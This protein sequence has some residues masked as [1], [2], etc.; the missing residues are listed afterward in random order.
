MPFTPI[1]EVSNGVRPEPVD[2]A[3]PR[4]RFTPVEGIGDAAPRAR[5][6]PIEE[7]ERTPPAL[8]QPSPQPTSIART[9][10]LENP[11][12]AIGEAGLNLG[13]QMVAQP[14]A[15][16]AGLA[17]LGGRALGLTDREPGDVVHSVGSALTYMP[18]GKMGQ[19]A[20]EIVAY[21]FQKLAEAGQWVGGKTLEATGSPLA[22]TVA[23]TAIN[24][25][26][27]ALT[28]SAIKRVA[29]KGAPAPAAPAAAEFR[30][31]DYVAYRRALESGGDATARNP[32]STATGIDQFT[33]G[34]WLRTV[35]QARPKWAEGLSRDQVLAER[36]NPA[37]SA[38]MARALDEQNVAALGRA[39][40]EVTRQSLYAAHH[41][42]EGTAVRFAKAAPDTPMAQ[43]LSAKQLAANQ[44]LAGKTKAQAIANWDSRARRAG[45][46]ERRGFTP[47]DE[48]APARVEPLPT[49]RAAAAD[50]PRRPG[51][52]EEA[53][54]DAMEVPEGAAAALDGERPSG[55]P[56]DQAAE[57]ARASEA[58]EPMAADANTLAPRNA[59]AL[60]S[61]ISDKAV[62]IARNVADPIRSL[63]AP[64]ERR[65][66][67]LRDEAGRIEGVAASQANLPDLAAMNREAATMLRNAAEAMEAQ[68][69]SRAT[70]RAAKYALM[71]ASD[72]QLPH[73]DV[74]LRN[75]RYPSELRRDGYSHLDQHQRIQRMVKEFDPEHV[76]ASLSDAGGAPIVARDGVVE[77]G[78]ARAGA[79]KRVYASSP[80]KAAAYREALMQRAPDFGLDPAAIQGMR[81]P[82]LVRLPDEPMPRGK[83]KELGMREPEPAPARAPAT[84]DEMP[85]AGQVNMAPGAN[86]VG[87]IDDSGKR[88]SAPPVRAAAADPAPVAKR[89]EPLRREDIIV[90]FAK[91]L[92]TT[93]YTGR[94]KG[95]GVQGTFRP[96]TGTVR[97]RRHADLEVTAHEVAHLIDQRSPEVRAA[98]LK[99]DMAKTYKTELQGLSY[100]RGKVYEGFAEFTRLYMTQPDVALAK[101]P[102]FSKWFD[103]FVERSPH[104]PAILKAREGMGRWFAQDA[105]DRARSKIGD[106]RPLSEAMDSRF[107]PWRQATLDDLHGIYRFERE[108]TGG[109]IEP[110]GAYETA[111][112]SRASASITDG[113]IRNGA[114]V[115]RPDGSFG[116]KGKGLE[117]ILKPIAGDLDSGLLYFVGESAHELMKQGRE[118]L[119]T[120]GEIDAMRALER[121][122]FKRAFAEYQEWN[123]GILDFA[124]AHGVINPE[125]RAQ[126]QRTQYLPFHRIGQLGQGKVKPGDWSGVK[127]LT[128]GTEN[129]RDI[130]GNITGNAALL[131]DKAVKNEARQKIADLAAGP[132]G[133]K[134]M[135]P[136]S[137]EARPIRVQREAVIDS[138]IKA[139]GIDKAD[140]TAAKTIGDL[141]T[142]LED[143]PALLE[144]MQKN[145]APAGSNVVAV[146]RKG[147]PEWY[148]VGDPILLRALESIDRQPQHWIVQWLGLPK[149]VGQTTITLDPGFMMANMARDTIQ[150][151]VMSRSG[152]RPI[153]DSLNGMRMR[154]TN[155]PVYR[156][157]VANGGGM[158]SV[159]LDQAHFKSTLKRFYSRKGIDYRTVLDTPEKLMGMVETIADAFETSTRLDE[160]KRAIDKGE[161]PRHAAYLAREVGTDFAMRGDSKALAFLQDTVMFLRA[162]M[163]SM[164]RMYR[165]VAHDPNRGA[166]AA[167]AGMLAMFSTALYLLNKDDTRYQDLPDWDRDG[168]WHFFVGDKHFR[169]PKIWEIGAISSGAERVAEKII[170]ADPQGLGK[171]FTRIVGATFNLNFMP[172]VLGPLYEQATNRNSFTKSPI[173][174]PGMENMQPFLRAKP[175]TSETVRAA[176][177]ATANLPEWAQVNPVRAEA[178]VRGYFNTWATYGLMLSDKTFFSDRQATMRADETPVVRRFVASEPPKHTKFETEFYDL[179]G[180]AKRLQGTLR[181]LD[182]QGQQGMAD[183]KERDPMAGEAKALEGASKSLTGINHEMRDVRRD[184]AL[185]ADEK[186]ARLDA[187]MVE[188]NALLKQAVLESRS[189]TKEKTR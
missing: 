45:V 43:L 178:L 163:S 85:T 2:S 154:L 30:H 67:M 58:I 142:M 48:A 115:V 15:G 40:V 138:I 36:T 78:N 71:E 177:M 131:I 7:V 128:G 33:D 26:P 111:R 158:S 99:G 106:H 12:T 109:K 188:R 31:T 22:A 122:E 102:A 124:E 4:G 68:G 91:E 136:I 94:V 152:F 156:E 165:G 119:F 29:G 184:V 161:H 14:L 110:G 129:L 28:P 76:T 157:F 10:A 139:A 3:P 9:I 24:A 183:A 153:I 18:R 179:L 180:S 103:G 74:M 72:L 23:D 32:R 160:F 141:R 104:G 6:T 27:M 114:P 164:D 185:S 44:Y 8:G 150:A 189:A 112:L 172:Q 143:S 117:E 118:H 166:I 57:I 82:V 100:D 98:W 20:A 95:K 37:R 113:A 171:D 38:E 51:L 159:Y 182:R 53:L 168:H 11:L 101:A 84:V 147:K 39:G 92:G 47:I 81:R 64:I 151:G 133:G 5:F 19:G 174:T 120:R 186:R 145:A 173:E 144:L 148:E 127:A 83:A 41:F 116:W 108:M 187:L 73:N 56:V 62:E 61:H 77:V 46:S 134:F 123:R 35:D 135:T 75:P 132:E 66:A 50:A 140:G 63:E 96:D 107:E 167:K 162:G 97:V 52:P 121:P 146:L 25:L 80:Q 59:D 125:T 170:E 175:T 49:E 155:D 42:G 70:A 55:R 1:E 21:P 13:T 130:L 34:T 90:P 105:L 89:P 79:L 176:G 17:A 126:W 16:L 88:P 86:Y 65:A 149:R 181:E 93:V 169:Y 54:P 69:A 87:M 137:P 60:A